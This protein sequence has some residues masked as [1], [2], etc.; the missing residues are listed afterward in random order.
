MP[1]K[2]ANPSRRDSRR[3]TPAQLWTGLLSL[4]VAVGL[5]LFLDRYLDRLATDRP[6]DWA[7]I[8]IEE[9]TGSIVAALL[10]PVMVYVTRRWP[11]L[12][13]R[14]PLHLPI[15][16]LAATLIAGVH[17]SA[18]S[19]LRTLLIVFPGLSD[20]HEYLLTP[21]AYLLSLPAGFVVYAVFSAITMVVDR[22][23]GARNRE[24]EAVEL[25][26]QL[27][28]AQMQVLRRQLEPQFLFNTL[29]SIAELVYANP[30]AA[31]EMI[32]RMS[33]LLRH[34]F[35]SE[36]S[37]ETTLAEEVRVLDLYLDIMRLRYAERLFVQVDAPAELARARV[38]RLLLQPL[39]EN[40]LRYGADPSLSLVAVRVSARAEDGALAIRVHDRSGCSEE[41]LRSAGLA[42][43][44]ERIV[45][46]YGSDYGITSRN[47]E[48]GI[49][50]IVKLPLKFAEDRLPSEARA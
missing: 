42:N 45:R 11:P 36:Q 49:E 22:Y 27:A 9:M 16:V 5:L 47:D 46:L 19:V 26:A 39:V 31:E 23:R 1:S 30:K 33:A 34:S 8:L 20:G 32:S 29:K 41:A 2:P 48:E 35:T 50:L 6:G 43:L 12:S 15:Q 4:A 17:T 14:W 3:F 10:V 25:R 38:P 24:L 7:R 18:T 40:A 13:A 44:G 37:H 28:Q 21:Q